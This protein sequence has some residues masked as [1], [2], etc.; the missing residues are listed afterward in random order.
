[1]T[2]TADCCKV[3]RSLH[4]FGRS[5]YLEELA[6]TADRGNTS[7]RDLETRVNRVITEGALEAASGPID[8]AVRTIIDALSGDPSPRVRARV[9]TRL[10]QRDVDPD[11][12]KNAYVSYRTIKNHLN[13]CE[14]IDTS[15]DES[16][17]TPA[18]ATDTIGWSETRHEA[19]IQRTLERL[20]SANELELRGSIEVSIHTTV[21][22]DRCH[23]S[24]PLRALLN[25]N[26]ACNCDT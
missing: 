6:R 2:D 25:G 15:R 5:S 21:T 16:P 7:L 11:Q 22:C 8:L 1:M 14:H 26:A 19:I 9:R 13:E 23:S 17:I 3:S 24:T 18:R 10:T 20:R 12:L 4:L